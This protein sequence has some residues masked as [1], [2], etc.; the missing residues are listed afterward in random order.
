MT[1]TSDESLY[2]YTPRNLPDLRL[3]MLDFWNDPAHHSWTKNVE[4]PATVDTD[5][6]ARDVRD[7][8]QHAHMFHVDRATSSIAATTEPDTLSM[9][10]YGFMPWDLPAPCG[11][12]YLDTGWL[13]ADGTWQDVVLTWNT[14]PPE[15]EEGDQGRMELHVHGPKQVVARALEQEREERPQ[16]YPQ[17]ADGGVL[18]RQ[19]PY[20]QS[21]PEF[22]LTRTMG[23]SFAEAGHECGYYGHERE[24]ISLVQLLF[25]TCHLMR[26]QL[27][28]N[29]TAVPTRPARR[30]HQR[31]G[32]EPPSVRTLQLR[33]SVRQTLAS[34]APDTEWRH[35]WVVRGHWRR[36]WYPSIEAHR[37]VWIAPFMKGPADAPVLGGQKVYTIGHRDG[38]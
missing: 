1:E 14:T 31:A 20:Q 5:G 33:P 3:R 32:L 7:T 29:H 17:R 8:L 10:E 2:H 35:Q 4:D 26:Q 6:L 15:N 18:D 19:S 28:E 13:L 9:T 21:Q 22:V 34:S 11:L 16:L 30:R 27:A 23:V 38:Q 12:M 36:Q 37:P 25:A 24:T